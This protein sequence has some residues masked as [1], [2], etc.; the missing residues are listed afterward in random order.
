MASS[1]RRVHAK[2]QAALTNKRLRDPACRRSINGN[3]LRH[4]SA[5]GEP[6]DDRHDVRFAAV[7]GRRTRR[8]QGS[9]RG[10]SGVAVRADRHRTPS[11]HA[12]SVKRLS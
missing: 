6:P 10:C 3:A 4:A 12:K 9:K 5:L 11:Q 7:D 2:P 1:S 8:E